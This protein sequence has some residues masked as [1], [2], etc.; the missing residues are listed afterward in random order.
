[1]RTH[2]GACVLCLRSARRRAHDQGPGRSAAHV[3]KPGHTRTTSKTMRRDV[4]SSSKP[5]SRHPA[6]HASIRNLEESINEQSKLTQSLF[7]FIRSTLGPRLS[8]LVGLSQTVLRVYREAPSNNCDSTDENIAELRHSSQSTT[9]KGTC[10]LHYV[11]SVRLSEPCVSPTWATEATGTS[12]QYIPQLVQTRLG[13]TLK[14]ARDFRSTVVN[15]K[16]SSRDKADA[17]SL[18]DT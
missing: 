5:H 11:C 3:I 18:S 17:A 10:S 8:S 1:M 12:S 6:I 7:R 16:P 4:S 15:T 2:C 9:Y 13:S 14:N